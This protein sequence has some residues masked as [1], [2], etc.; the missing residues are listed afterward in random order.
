MRKLAS[1]IVCIGFLVTLSACVT[2]TRLKPENAELASGFNAQLGLEYMKQGDNK[3]ALEKLKKSLRQNPDNA[4]AHHYI[5]VLYQQLGEAEDAGEHFQAALSLTPEDSSLQDSYGVFLCDQGE[6][7]EALE[8]FNKVLAN[9]VYSAKDDVK[10][11]IGI[12]AQ[13][14]GDLKKANR[15]LNEALRKNPRSPKALLA[16]T[17][18]RFDEEDFETAHEFLYRYFQVA[19]KNPQSLWLGVLLERKQGNKNM[20]ASYGVFLKGK[21]PDS[22]EAGLL[23]KLEASERR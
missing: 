18:L 15:Y 10:E 7:S 19:R 3:V 23:R 13:L 14:K 6:Y 11:N 12:C 20:A 17:Q 2:D 22:K 1:I 4:M 16:I 8:A 5:A 9:P 21:Y